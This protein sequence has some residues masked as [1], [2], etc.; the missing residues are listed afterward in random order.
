M[1]YIWSQG[2][3]GED[4][5]GA[6]DGGMR[7]RWRE[8]ETFQKRRKSRV[9]SPPDTLLSESASLILVAVGCQRKCLNEHGLAISPDDLTLI[10]CGAGRIIDSQNLPDIPI[11]FLHQSGQNRRPSHDIFPGVERV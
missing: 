9:T 5:S 6:V 1:I 8:R 10:G 7:F 11:V 3:C 4:G 2:I